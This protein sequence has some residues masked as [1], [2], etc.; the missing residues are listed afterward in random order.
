MDNEYV[1]KALEDSKQLY[2]LPQTLAEVLRVIRDDSSSA[3]D[4]AH[5]LSRDPALTSKVLRIVNSPF[6]GMGREV[7]SVSQAVV[8]LGLRQVTALALSTSIYS[9]TDKWASAIDRSRFWRHSL[10]V[11]IASRTIAEKV[12]YRNLEEIFVAGLV[13]DIGLLIM[14]HAY[15]EDFGR[16]WKEVPKRGSLVDLEEDVW[17]TN[18]ARVGQ[19]LLEQWRLPEAICEAVGQH[20]TV[21][22]A[23]ETDPELIPGQIVALANRISQFPIG[24]VQ[25]TKVVEDKE[26]REIIRGNLQLDADSLLAIQQHLFHQTVNECKYLEIDIGST[27]DILQEANRMLFKQYAAVESLL[28]ENRRMQKQV[29]GEQ[30]KRGFLESLKTTTATFTDYLNQM[31][32]SILER[33]RLVQEGIASGAIVDPKDLVASSVQEIIDRVQKLS[34]VTREVRELAERETALYYDQSVVTD[35]EDRIRKALETIEEPVGTV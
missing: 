8:M 28:E 11:A 26:N 15:P 2:S 23:G 35:V 27:E 32:E 22:V 25:S 31:S 4:L 30:V 10:E 9:M 19:F 6:Y 12:G 24:E 7:A 1:K 21:F 29:A 17:G 20:H 14:E 33:A 34:P 16:L 13:H 5:V 18:H 3:D